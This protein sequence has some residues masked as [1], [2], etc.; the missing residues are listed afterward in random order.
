MIDFDRYLRQLPL[1]KEGKVD[2][3]KL[4]ASRVTV[5]G[6]GGLGS[7]C[8]LYLAAAGVGHI[9]VIDSQAVELSNLNRQILYDPE[10]IGSKKATVAAKK[11]TR[12][13]PDIEVQPVAEELA[14]AEIAVKSFKPQLLIDCTDNLGARREL[15]HLAHA[16]RV[17]LVFAMVEGYRMMVGT[18]YPGETACFEC[19]FKDKTAQQAPPPV[20]GFTP[21]TAGAVEAALA[22]Q[23]LL[24]SKPLAGKMLAADLSQMSFDLLQTKKRSDCPVCKDYA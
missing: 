1:F 24:G 11:L 21:G 2:Q 22:V 17:P 14:Q 7:P 20:I 23:I 13:N 15:N 19:I 3:E 12:F 8:L 6:A 16:L 9:Q 5:V 18:F 4:L 10:D